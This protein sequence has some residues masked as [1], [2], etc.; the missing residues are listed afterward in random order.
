M[1][2]ILFRAY[3]AHSQ[4]NFFTSGFLAARLVEQDSL[5]IAGPADNYIELPKQAAPH[6]RWKPAASPQIPMSCSLIWVLQRAVQL[7]KDSNIAVTDGRAL[8]RQTRVYHG[9]QLQVNI[10]SKLGPHAHHRTE[11][12]NERRSEDPKFWEDIKIA[13][14]QAKIRSTISRPQQSPS[15]EA[16]EAVKLTPRI[17]DY[18]MPATEN[19][20]LSE[21]RGDSANSKNAWF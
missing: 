8:A 14:P 6:L 9:F 3:S 11:L 7:G 17:R 18:P 15:A 1:P 21:R 19:A 5:D 12:E 16:P 10:R 2:D 20:T 4:G 13:L